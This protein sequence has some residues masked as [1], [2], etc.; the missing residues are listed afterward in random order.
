VLFL[1][2]GLPTVCMAVV[3]F[4]FLPDSPQTAKFLTEEEKDVARRRGVLQVGAD[5]KRVGGIDWK[6]IG[7]GL[8]DVKSWILGVSTSLFDF[9]EWKTDI[10]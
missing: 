6:E 10:D 5:T 2:E 9:S 3:A 8:K 4:F 1:V 7:E